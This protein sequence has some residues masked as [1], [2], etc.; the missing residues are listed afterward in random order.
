MAGRTQV[1]PDEPE[2]PPVELTFWRTLSRYL[3][4]IVASLACGFLWSITGARLL[5]LRV[6]PTIYT[7]VIA[8]AIGFLVMGYLWLSLDLSRP[9]AG[10]DESDRT[11]QLFVLWLGIPLAVIAVCAVV[12]IVAV[13][14]GATVLSS[15]IPGQR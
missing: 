15:G 7:G 11:K 12:A 8:L 13:I 9:A 14:L 6:L 3:V 5:N 10:V 4:S 1:L 2:R